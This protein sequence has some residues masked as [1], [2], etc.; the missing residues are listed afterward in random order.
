[1]E[2]LEEECNPGKCA[3]RRK[4]AK[5][6]D[7][8]VAFITAEEAEGFKVVGIVTTSVKERDERAKGEQMSNAMVSLP[9]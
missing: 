9:V 7:V 3:K 1:M 5:V 8:H 2:D 6:G 4:R